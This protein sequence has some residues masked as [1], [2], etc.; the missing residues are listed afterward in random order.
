[1]KDLQPGHRKII[2]TLAGGQ[3]SHTGKTTPRAKA[4]RNKLAAKT[5]V[6]KEPLPRRAGTVKRKKTNKITK[7]HKTPRTDRGARGRRRVFF[8]AEARVARYSLYLGKRARSRGSERTL[9]QSSTS[10]QQDTARHSG[11]NGEKT[12]DESSCSQGTCSTKFT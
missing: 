3:C 8:A 6:A 12:G 1:M 11:R 4:P 7:Q 2:F 5:R 9:A 10:N